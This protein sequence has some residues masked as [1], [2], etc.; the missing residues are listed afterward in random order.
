MVDET[1][2]VEQSNT[3]PIQDGADLNLDL[4]DRMSDGMD[5]AWYSSSNG[6]MFDKDGDELVNPVTGKS[7]HSEQEY[8]DYVA[9]VQKENAQANKETVK[10]AEKPKPMSRSFDTIV[11]GEKGLDINRMMELAKPNQSYQYKNELIP[12]VDT[13]QNPTPKEPEKTPVQKVQEYRQQRIDSISKPMVALRDAVK[14]ALVQTGATPQAA[15]AFCSEIANN[16]YR[17]HLGE[18]ENEYQKKQAE[19]IA[20]MAEL[21]AK[22]V[23]DPVEQK[24]VE[25]DSSQNIARLAQAYYQDHGTDA[26]FS[27]INGYNDEKGTFQ[28]GPAAP[29][30]DLLTLVASNGKTFGTEQERVKFYGDNFQK[31]MA[32]PVTAQALFDIA[33][34]Y[35]LGKNI[36]KAYTSGKSTGL[37][38]AKQSNKFVKPRPTA[39]SNG[40]STADDED[41]SM[42]QM[43]K[44]FLNR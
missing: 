8:R 5:E 35:W 27:L 28:R 16:V 24:K 39:G 19:A 40:V 11:S 18:I 41:S 13:K 31:L 21:K 14:Q 17:Q 2:T 6:V 44:S 32:N 38:E 4:Q 36:D 22:A 10:T 9:T 3:E 12:T 25:T 7:F 30:I 15:E 33:H 42:P 26:F 23:L 20:E 29:V 34:N 37:K 43:L 1:T